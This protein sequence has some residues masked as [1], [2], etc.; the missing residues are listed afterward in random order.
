MA[1]FLLGAQTYLGRPPQIGGAFEER[2]VGAALGEDKV[3]AYAQRG[4][5]VGDTDHPVEQTLNRLQ[6]LFQFQAPC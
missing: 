1:G 6:R 4:F 5:V 2:E 3:C